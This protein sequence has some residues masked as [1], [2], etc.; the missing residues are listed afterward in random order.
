MLSCASAVC[1]LWK[2]YVE[3][4]ISTTGMRRSFPTVWE[5]Y[6]DRLSLDPVEFGREYRRQVCHEN[7]LRTGKATAAR[8]YPDAVH[9]SVR[10]PYVAW[11][12]GKA[13]FS[14]ENVFSN[15]AAW[16]GTTDLSRACTT[17]RLIP[18]LTQTRI[19]FIDLATTLDLLFVR[20]VPEGHRASDQRREDLVYSIP[21]DRLVWSK[22]RTYG[23]RYPSVEVG[24]RVYLSHVPA[25]STEYDLGFV[26][27]DLGTGEEIYCRHFG[28][29]QGCSL[30]VLETQDLIVLREVYHAT[31]LAGSTGDIIRVVDLVGGCFGIEV[32]PGSGNLVFAYHDNLP[33]RHHHILH[34][35]HL[36]GDERGGR[37][38]LEMVHRSHICR[39]S[40]VVPWPDALF[41]RN[42][43]DFLAVEG[44]PHKI[45]DLLSV[46]AARP[47]VK[48]R[49]RWE[50]RLA[51]EEVASSACLCI[52]EF[53]PNFNA[54]M[55]PPFHAARPAS[56]EGG[57]NYATERGALI[58]LPPTSSSM[59]SATKEKTTEKKMSDMKRDR[60]PRRP[61]ESDEGP[62]G[63]LYRRF[64]DENYALLF[65][66]HTTE[67]S[68]LYLLSFRPE[69]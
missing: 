33:F 6:K 54:M 67:T 15:K 8:M 13:K 34:F 52:E 42:M 40:N 32:I 9:F 35:Y 44:V 58:T 19:E 27:E 56:R 47:S 14:V 41:R 31:I 69:W 16:Q 11:S 10:V 5:E 51:R 21:E 57:S 55:H 66:T 68:D 24:R 62:G 46:D 45:P 29:V 4:Y 59:P 39:R 18:A 28:F 38:T 17:T 1:R 12:D 53:E 20:V 36:R 30:H 37:S 64:V 43:R 22:T 26:A 48:R 3:D 60:P 23:E 65:G 2:A 7:A 25:R 50:I 61:F 49:D 63:F